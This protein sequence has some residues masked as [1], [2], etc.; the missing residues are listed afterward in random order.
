MELLVNN[1]PLQ[2]IQAQVG[3]GQLPID[4]FAQ[5]RGVQLRGQ[6]LDAETGEG[7]SGVTFVLLSADF[8]ISNFEWKQDQIYASAVTDRNGRFQIDRPLEFTTPY[9][10]VVNAHGYLPITADGFEVTSETA[11][12]LEVVIPLTHD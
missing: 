10:V 7:I 9:S 5:A 12:P 1:V 8:S 2:S 11:N 3:I 4:L 6:I